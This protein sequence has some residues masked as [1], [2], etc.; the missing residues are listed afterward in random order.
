MALDGISEYWLGWAGG[1]SILE[2]ELGPGGLLALDCVMCHGATCAWSPRV[3]AVVAVVDEG[4][5]DVVVLGL[6]ANTQSSSLDAREDDAHELAERGRVERN[7][8]VGAAAL[9]VLGVD[10]VA[11]D[12]RFRDSANRA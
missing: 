9:G 8:T 12:G 3:F 10:A 2:V 6:A 1:G 7:D 4:Q 5:V 11:R